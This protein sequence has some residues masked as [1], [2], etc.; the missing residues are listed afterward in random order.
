MSK[1]YT[2]IQISDIP[3]DLIFEGYYW[4]SDK[5]KP[6]DCDQEPIQQAWFSK[7]PFVVEANFYNKAEGICIQVRSIDGQ[8]QVARIDLS[9]LDQEHFSHQDHIGHDLSGRNY[10]VVTAWEPETDPLCADMAVLVPTW[11]AFAGFTT[12]KQS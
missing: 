11:T 4:Y 8:Y 9:D 7:M 3:E 12:S 2:L 1:R 6:V 10:R 5:S